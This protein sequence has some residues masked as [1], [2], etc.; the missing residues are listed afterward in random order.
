MSL[1]QVQ[2]A[3]WQR[4]FLEAER[5]TGLMITRFA[6]SFFSPWVVQPFALVLESIEQ[7][8]VASALALRTFSEEASLH[9][10][11]L[12]ARSR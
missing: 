11:C 12:C 3:M 7:S 4:P 8:R 10:V 1:R 5:S 6:G 9:P 2:R